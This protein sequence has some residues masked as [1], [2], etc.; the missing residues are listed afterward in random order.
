MIINRTTY[1]KTVRVELGLELGAE[2]ADEAWMLLREPSTLEWLELQEMAQ[3]KQERAIVAKMRT[4]F[5]ALVLDH[6]LYTDEATKLEN[7]DAV[8]IVFAKLPAAMKLIDDYIGVMRDPFAK[9]S[10]E[11]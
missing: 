7:A 4:L 11:K 6:N 10:G 1:L 8:D 5:P 9:T 2:K 3:E